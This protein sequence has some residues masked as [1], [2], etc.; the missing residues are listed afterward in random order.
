[1]TATDLTLTGD[2]RPLVALAAATEQVDGVAH[3]AVRTVYVRALERVADCGVAVVGGPASYLVDM[4]DRFDGLVFGGHQTDVL[5]HWYGSED[6]PG[7]ADRPRDELALS[8]LPTALRAGLPVLGICRG[9]QELNVALGG[10]LRD[11]SALPSGAN[12]R[13]DESLPR[14]QQYL[15]AHE[16]HLSQ[17]GVLRRLLG[18]PTISVNSLHH[19]AI[20]HLAPGMRIEAVA[21]DGVIEAVSAADT[22]S[23]CL[24]VQWH[25]EWYA[26]AD[27][28]S[29][30]IF[31]EFGTAA[32]VAAQRRTSL[33][34][35]H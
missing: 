8:V 2:R 7:P 35:N 14:D 9:M 1:M 12:H 33:S 29:T 16:V 31:T 13:E 30:A 23:F 24:A 19:Q 10:T 26:E 4:V 21:P 3:F 34:A 6:R 32:R 15:P 27:P 5:P 22:D 11:L 28:I 20:D 17:K 25:P 18:Q